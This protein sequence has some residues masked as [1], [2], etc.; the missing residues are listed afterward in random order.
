MADRQDPLDGRA[1]RATVAD[2][3]RLLADGIENGDP[4][5]LGEDDQA[6]SA[7]SP[8]RIDVRSQVGDDVTRVRVDLSWES[9]DAAAADGTASR[10][11]S[12]G[13]T[14][15]GAAVDTGDEDE[16]GVLATPDDDLPDPSVGTRNE[17]KAAHEF[18]RAVHFAGKGKTT[19]ADSRFRQAIEAD[20]A[21]ATI[22]RR[23]ADFLQGVGE[24]PRAIAQF[25][26]ALEIA[27]EDP[28]LRVAVA[29]AHWSRGD[30]DD[31]TEQFETALDIAPENPD[32]L[33][34]YGRFCWEERGDVEAAVEHLR[35]AIDADPD[36]ALA[37][38]NF[39]V[40]LREGGRED[41]AATHYERALDLGEGDATVHAE[42]GH[43]L[44][45]SGDVEEA[46]RHYAK[47]RELGAQI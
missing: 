1:D 4:L 29:N 22:R 31:A 25:E 41:R 36:H 35:T 26:R 30:A 12:R 16:S 37:H 24:E 47:A 17:K 27:P 8:V 7:S 6:L 14:R 32:V 18:D 15:R 46:A 10:D 45:A 5:P 44:W 11:R 40:L 23:Y 21:D 2:Q 43:Y 3:L 9:D 42:Y 20:P 33:S 13:D 39:A 38:L 28:Q 19:A 34:T